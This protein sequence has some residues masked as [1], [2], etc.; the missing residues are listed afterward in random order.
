MG[1][2]LEAYFDHV[3]QKS[4]AFVGGFFSIF[5]I[6][7]F[8]DGWLGNLQGFAGSCRIAFSLGVLVDA[9]PSGS[10][11]YVATASGFAPCIY[12]RIVMW[13]WLLLFCFHMRACMLSRI[14]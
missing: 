12:C 6:Y 5:F 8:H 9:S 3:R 10:G 1:M 4:K 2:Q 11:E 14:T 7:T 13:G